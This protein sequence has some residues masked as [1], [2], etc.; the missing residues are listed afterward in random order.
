MARKDWVKIKASPYKGGYKSKNGQTIIYP[1][2]KIGLLGGQKV[3][4]FFKSLDTGEEFMHH[5][6]LRTRKEAD[7]V[8][9][10]YMRKHT[11]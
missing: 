2:F 7:A 6:P 8:M 10:D 11:S 4:V 1:E 5:K 3:T 9:Q